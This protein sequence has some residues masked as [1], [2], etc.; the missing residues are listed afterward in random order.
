[1]N[2]DRSTMGEDVDRRLMDAADGLVAA[3]EALREAKLAMDDP[4]LSAAAD[5]QRNQ[6]FSQV[7]NRVENGAKKAEEALRKAIIAAAP[8]RNPAH[9]ACYRQADARLASAR[10]ELRGAAREDDPSGRA[11]RL[12]VAI[13][14]VDQGLDVAKDLI[15][16]GPPLAASPA[17]QPEAQAVFARIASRPQDQTLP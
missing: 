5:Q 9:F 1:M 11:A 10:A 12:S 7:T 3:F 14:L 4:R 6:G 2:Q 17:D 16:C 13:A 8:G 15:F